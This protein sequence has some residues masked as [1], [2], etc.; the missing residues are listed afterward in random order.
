M[1]AIRLRRRQSGVARERMSRDLLCCPAAAN[2][3]ENENPVDGLL[4]AA[5]LTKIKTHAAASAETNMRGENWF[6]VRF[7]RP[8]TESKYALIELAGPDFDGEEVVDCLFTRTGS[9]VT[10]W[11]R[12]PACAIVI[13]SR[14]RDTAPE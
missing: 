9:P 10:A 12:R 5:R 7:T 6:Q 2:A 13:R 3:S 4:I 8:D 14:L 1:R 11:S